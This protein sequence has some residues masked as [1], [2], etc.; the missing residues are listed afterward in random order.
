GR[1]YGGRTLCYL[2]CM[3]DLDVEVGTPLLA[4]LAPALT[5]LF[6]AG[7]WYCGRVNAVGRRGIE[8]ALPARARG[9]FMPVLI[10]GIHALLAQ[11]PGLAEEVAELQGRLEP[12]L[13][14]PDPATIGARAAAAFSD[15]EPAWPFAAFQSIDLQLAARDVDAIAGG[16]YLAILGDMH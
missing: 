16:D 13:A 1:T 9:A 5:T 8:A 4:E 12:L 6:E 3:R 14:D 7:R 15:Y 2:D 11:P 10:E